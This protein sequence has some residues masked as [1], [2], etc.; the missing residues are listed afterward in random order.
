MQLSIYRKDLE[1]VKTDKVDY[2][3]E[4]WDT[5]SLGSFDKEQSVTRIEKRFHH[6]VIKEF[7][8]GIGEDIN[9]Y[10]EVS[11]YLNDLWMY[12]LKTIRHQ[13]NDTISGIWQFLMEDIEFNDQDIRQDFKRK[14]VEKKD[15]TSI[16]RQIG[17]FIGNYLTIASRTGKPFKDIQREIQSLTIMTEIREYL[18]YRQQNEGLFF[19]QL[20]QKY[21]ERQI[22]TRFSTVA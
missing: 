9:S 18:S 15:I 14:Q 1:I 2:Y 17:L 19:E 12:A 11:N 4:L 8:R 3:H 16:S 10:L 22:A 7:E 5:F 21:L 6:S 20:K 13:K